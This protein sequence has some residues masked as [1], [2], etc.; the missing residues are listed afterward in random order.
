VKRDGLVGLAVRGLLSALGTW[1]ALLLALA[2]NAALAFAVVRPVGVALHETLDRSPWADVLLKSADATF[3]VHFTRQ[4]PDV[5]GDVAKA[6]DLVTGVSPSRR[7]GGTTLARLLPKGGAMTS[8]L[9][10]G[11]LNLALAALLSGGFAGRFGASKDRASLQ[12]FGADCGRYGLSSLVLGALTFGLVVAA[13]RWLYVGTGQLYDP[14]DFRYEW[15]AALLTLLRLGLFLVAASYARTLAAFARASMGLAGN[16]NLV[17]ALGQAVGTIL[18]RP[19]KALALEVLCGTAALAPPV[20]WGFFAPTWDGTDT[21][22]FFLILAG[23]QLVVFLR[24]ASRAA[25]LGSA[26]AWLDRA[27]AASSPAPAEAAPESSAA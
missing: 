10:F 14:D 9:A 11:L 27:R 12:A 22:R 6:E 20:L 16:A 24:I 25:H 19:G 8:L 23:Q 26:T 7:A 4:H 15:Q 5:L 17:S 3:F 1:K 13:W 21:S 18:R 2:L